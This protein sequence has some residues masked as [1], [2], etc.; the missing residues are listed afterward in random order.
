MKIIAMIPA[1]LG[2][3]RL[4]HKNLQPFKGVPLIVHAIRKAKISGVF[5]E[6]WVNS[7]AEVF[8]DIAEQEGVNFHKRPKELADNNA[9]SE[10][11]VYQFL[12]EHQCDYVVQ[13]HSIAPLLSVVDTQNFVSELEKGS[14]D[15]LLSVDNVQIECAYENSPVNFSYDAKT[16][17]Q[18]LKPVQRIT[19]SI[20]GWKRNSYIE[21]YDSK[22]CATY[23]G[24]VAYFPIDRLAGHI[25][26]TQEDLDIAEALYDLTV[27]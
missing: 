24:N 19:W 26:K 2:S 8:A 5:D 9:T 15:A 25:I 10:D 11:F 13:L 20:T 17:S 6:I 12:K 27:K 16:N 23:S 21:A 1:R 14:A 7:E 3:Q 18:D 4:K 22:K